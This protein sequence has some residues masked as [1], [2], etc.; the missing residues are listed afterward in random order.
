MFEKFDK[1]HEE[2]KA[3][4]SNYLNSEKDYD[5][6][7]VHLLTWLLNT[8]HNPYSIF[9]DETWAG[10]LD[11]SSGFAGLCS[12]IHHALV[13]DGAISFVVIKNND[14]KIAFV[15]KNEDNIQKY[16]CNE[17]ELKRGGDIKDIKFLKD[18]Y[19]FTKAHDAYKI[20]WL[21][22]CFLSDSGRVLDLESAIKY[23]SKYDDFDPAW[24]EEA[25]NCSNYGGSSCRQ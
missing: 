24:I 19:E 23:Y 3:E 12:M 9:V 18:A 21:K 14:P 11:T 5:K 8:K 7:T 25:K 15:W 13:D 6:E 1:S 4:I 10:S 17:H 16:V 2:A 20:K 22:K